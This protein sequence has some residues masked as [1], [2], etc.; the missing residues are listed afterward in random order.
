LA[1][2]VGYVLQGALNPI[3]GAVSDRLSHPWGRRR[4]FVLFGAPALAVGFAGVW[5]IGGGR[6]LWVLPLYCAAFTVVA[7]PYTTLLPSLA[8]NEPLRVRLTIAASVLG[9]VA[10]GAALVGGPLLLESGSFSAFAI[11]G[12]AA[13]WLG[14]F[15]PALLLREPASEARAPADRAPLLTSALAIVR[16]R[17]MALFLAGNT[18]LLAAVVALTMV[19]PFLP[20]LLIGRERAYT[21]V[22]N[23]WLFGGMVATMPLMMRLRRVAKPASV[24]AAAAL[25]GA[26]VLAGVSALAWAS[27]AT[28]WM[29]W[30]SYFLLGS[31]MLMALAGPPLVLSRLAERDGRRREG[32]SFGLNGMIAVGGGRALAAI[33]LGVLIGG[34]HVSSAA[35]AALLCLALSAALL[36]G[37]AGLLA[38]SARAEST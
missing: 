31:T 22:L 30:L 8:P 12:F 38:A 19:G 24:M 17:P 37:G 36:L 27:A 6:G 35:S 29:W 15:L 10:A 20:E 34:E 9:L 4:P 33:M 3:I 18:C 21:G 1:L 28:L 23:G 11:A 5:L 14:L 26:A 2:L 16:Q 25:A 7:Q 32:L 13:V